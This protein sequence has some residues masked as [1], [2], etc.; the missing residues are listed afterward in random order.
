MK[1]TTI[2][3]AGGLSTRFGQDK[4]LV[5]INNKEIIK[6]TVD[7]FLN[8]ENIQEIIILA[9][10]HLIDQMSSIFN[11]I[12]KVKVILGGSSRQE[13]VF[14]GLKA[15]NNPDFVIIH[16]GARPFIS[17]DVILKTLNLALETKAAI[18]G[19]KATDTIKLVN[20]D[21]NLIIKTID[22]SKLYNIQTPQIFQFNTILQAHLK[23]QHLS[24]TD[25]S[26][27][28]E[29]L[30]IPVFIIDGNYDNIKI[31]TKKDL[32]IARSL[33]DPNF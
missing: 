26:S 9:P 31:T 22:R 7:K 15:A 32:A 4:L 23:L 14:N 24:F 10:D 1:I 5:K 12:S 6:Y 2:I 20:T 25:D 19:V 27:M 33:L 11:D 17:N 21:N 29:Y 3:P 13:S 30:N 18:V 16:D 8:F 28:L